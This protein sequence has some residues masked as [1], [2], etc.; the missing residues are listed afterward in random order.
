M[1]AKAS[2]AAHHGRVCTLLLV[3]VILVADGLRCK[4][5]L[6]SDS[7]ELDAMMVFTVQVGWRSTLVR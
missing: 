3:W 1:A 5:G 4:H 2:G 7:R 6:F